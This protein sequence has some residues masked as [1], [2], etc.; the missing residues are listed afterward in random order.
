MRIFVSHAAEDCEIASKLVDLLE[1][2]MGV[3]D[4]HIF[5]TSQAGTIKNGE[6]F[7]Q[8]ILT[9]LAEAELVV[10]LIS[11]AYLRSQF[12]LAEAGAAMLKKMGVGCQLTVDPSMLAT[13]AVFAPASL[14]AGV[15]AG[16]VMKKV[17]CAPKRSL[18]FSLTIPPTNFSEISGVLHGVQVGS[19]RSRETLTELRQLVRVN[20]DCK[21]VAEVKWVTRLE[22]FIKFATAYGES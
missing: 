11:R 12:C 8:T 6:F 19:I 9:N 21:V 2:G 10:C 5:F 3:P 20:P 13:A 7:V 17:K 14:V 22:Q 15:F 1:I 18:I 16:E 4:D